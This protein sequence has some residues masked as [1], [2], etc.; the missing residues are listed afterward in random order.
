MIQVLSSQS[1]DE[2]ESAIAL[3]AQRHNGSVLATTH[4]GALLG[5]EGDAVVFTVCQSELYKALLSADIRFAAFLPC[6]IAALRR[7]NGVLLESVS[8]REFCRI[9]HRDDLEPLAAPLETSLRE[10]MEDAARPGQAMALAANP[11]SGARWGATEDQV[12]MRATVAQRIDRHGSKIEDLGGT[13][14]PETLGG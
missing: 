10:M 7:A 13:G 2:M 5:S 14:K 6:R 3:A 12:N 8:P 4:L 9:I 11:G 1:I